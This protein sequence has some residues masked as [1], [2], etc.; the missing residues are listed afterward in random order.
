MN[1]SNNVHLKIRTGKY[2]LNYSYESSISPS[3]YFATNRKRLTRNQ[4]LVKPILCPEVT[5]GI[6]Y[7]NR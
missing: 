6:V 5:Y 7:V 1:E 3:E 2:I 4:I